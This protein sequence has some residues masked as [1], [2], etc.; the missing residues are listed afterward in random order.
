MGLER[1]APPAAS[2][3]EVDWTRALAAAQARFPHAELRMASLPAAPGKPAVVRLRQPQEWHANGRTIVYIDP[4]SSSVLAVDDAL[5]KPPQARLYNAFWPIHA[6]KVGGL[7]WKVLTFVSGVALAAL[8]A[9]GAESYRRKLFARPPKP[10][11]LRTPTDP[12]VSI[13]ARG[14]R[15]GRRT[16]D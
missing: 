2:A 13:R 12:P 4:G 16:V 10:R 8:A 1:M 15:R 14:A 6:S 3:G 11:P 7:A 5:A 9:Y